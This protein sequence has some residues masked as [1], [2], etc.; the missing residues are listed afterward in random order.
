MPQTLREVFSKKQLTNISV[1][2][3]LISKSVAFIYKANPKTVIVMFVTLGIF[4]TFSTIGSFLQAR[5]I[6]SIVGL[7]QGNDEM[8]TFILYF[9]TLIAFEFITSIESSI[10]NFLDQYNYLKVQKH[11]RMKILD[12]LSRL[13]LYYFENS[14]YQNLISNV[15]E[16]DFRI[17]NFIDIILWFFRYF[18]V[19]GVSI[20]VLIKFSVWLTLLIVLFSIPRLIARMVLGKRNYGLW[21]ENAE[22]RRDYNDTG[23]YLKSEKYLQE[24]R[25]Y[26]LIPF[27]RE[28]FVKLFDNFLNK[29][30]RLEKK[31]FIAG[32][33][34][35]A[36]SVIGY[37]IAIFMLSK[38]VILGVI[39]IGIFTFY[40]SAIGRIT[41]SLY[42]I[43]QYSSSLF[44]SSLFVSDFF[45]FIELKPKVIDGREAL[46]LNN[47]PEIKFE[48]VGFKYPNS[49]VYVLRD[50]NLTIKPGE[51]IAIVGE[52]GAGKSTMT[53]IMQR[54][55]DV[56]EGELLIDGKNI[57]TIKLSDWYLN[58]SVLSQDF[59]RY[60][61]NAK[62]NIGIGKKD[63]NSEIEEVIDAAKSSGAHEFIQ[64][65]VKKYDQVLSKHYPDGIDPSTGQWQKIAL[66]RAFVKDS[67]VLIL[68]E[69]TSAIDPKAEAE[70]FNML[71]DYAK[72]KT[73]II[74]SHR[75]STVR[76]ADRII[77]LNDGKIIEEGSH[78]ELIKMDGKYKEAYELQ[79]QGYIDD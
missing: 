40:L 60:H 11:V 75:F 15:Q 63:Q 62:T 30:L 56:N 46:I 17:I 45:K 2:F 74:I 18:M 24:I 50:F 13:D 38:E 64:K 32:I 48:K 54:F 16:N 43:I 6:D 77:V 52:N 55:Y 25:V 79:K 69:P 34:V 73:V 26:N 37:A 12:K 42:R 68:D 58:L 31:R 61:F 71:L 20:F 36:I 59:N 72:D 70:I 51:K 53:K 4:S 10:T 7:A 66:A 76:K 78:S 27:L 3:K 9:A 57:K 22:V 33:L 49:K 29:Q 5:L 65:Y 19:L 14:K 21:E 67:K 47:P 35:D 39:S 44:E 8:A 28:R 41:D 1:T 23:H